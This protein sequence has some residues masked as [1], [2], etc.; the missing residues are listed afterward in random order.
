MYE[1]SKMT[2]LKPSLYTWLF[3]IIC[4][5]L[6]LLLSIPLFITTETMNTVILFLLTTKIGSKVAFQDD[7]TLI[8]KMSRQDIYITKGVLQI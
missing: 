1:V 6:L 2:S 4:I 7:W 3:I 5:F 8:H